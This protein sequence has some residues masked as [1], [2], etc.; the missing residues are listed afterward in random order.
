MWWGWRRNFRRW[1]T[2]KIEIRR[3]LFVN[4][5]WSHFWSWDLCSFT[6]FS[7]FLFSKTQ[8]LVF[9]TSI[10]LEGD[11]LSLEM[12]SFYWQNIL[13]TPKLNTYLFHRFEP[14]INKL[15]TN[16]SANRQVFS[17]WTSG[18]AVVCLT[19]TIIMMFVLQFLITVPFQFTKIHYLLLNAT[20][21]ILGFCRKVWKLEWRVYFKI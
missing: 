5:Y 14:L 7:V 3:S 2:A 20:I 15:S 4:L 11:Q 21:F 10:S 16:F 18:V 17:F 12:L 13:L 1:L 8:K 19:P 9:T 6:C